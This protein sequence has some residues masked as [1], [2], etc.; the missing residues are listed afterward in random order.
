MNNTD[1]DMAAL[2]DEQ[3]AHYFTLAREG[4]KYEIDKFW[5]RSVFFW[6]FIAASFIAYAKGSEKTKPLEKVL[7][8][9][10]GL[11]CSFTW[12]LSNRGSK[13]WQ[14]AW[15]RKV[16]RIEDLVLGAKLFSHVEDRQPKGVWGA[17]NFSVS[18]LTIALSDFTC[19]IWLGLLLNGADLN[20][21]HQIGISDDSALY[22]VLAVTFVYIALLLKFTLRTKTQTSDKERIKVDP[23][24]NKHKEGEE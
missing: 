18:K 2:T 19:I 1:L 16:E 5:Q 21:A 23:V 6:G 14:E 13:Y 12:T 9:C 22:A 8:S 7:I 11:I 10:F 3:K 4:R 15:E 24:D 17:R 20:I